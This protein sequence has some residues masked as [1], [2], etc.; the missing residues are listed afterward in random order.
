MGYCL[1]RR[2]NVWC[3]CLVRAFSLPLPP[4][5]FWRASEGASCVSPDEGDQDYKRNYGAPRSGAVEWP[6]NDPVDLAQLR[7]SGHKM[8]LRSSGGLGSAEA[9]DVI[10]RRSRFSATKK[11]PRGEGIRGTP[12]G[13]TGEGEN[14]IRRQHAG[15]TC[16]LGC[17]R[18]QATEPRPDARCGRP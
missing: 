7:P 5:G 4:C 1:S 14:S 15:R 17:H 9:L 12:G 11:A 18:N 16:H 6:K 8:P 13:T 2:A 3:S 10:F